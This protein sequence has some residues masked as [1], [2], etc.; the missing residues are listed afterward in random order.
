MSMS[1]AASRAAPSIILAVAL[2]AT[3]LLAG[4]ARAQVTS[5]NMEPLA[6]FNDYPVPP[7]NVAYGY[8]A[9]WSYIH[10]DGREYAVLGVGSGTAIYN[11]TDPASSYRVGFIPGPPSIWRE[12][13]SYRNW[14]YVVTEGTGAG[15]GL[16]IIR[17]TNPEAPVLAASYT[18]GFTHS[19][20]VSVDTSRALLVCN[21]TR[22]FL[23]NAAGMHVL[24]LA[25]PE[26][27][28]ELSRW[29]AGG[30]IVPFQ[31]Y[32]HDC[33]LVGN[34]LYAS[35]VYIG[36]ERVIDITNPSVPTE[37]T[38]WSYPS[39]YYCHSAWPDASGRWLYVADEQNGQTLRVFDV[40][41]IMSPVLV[42]AFTCNPASIVHNPRVKGNTLYLANYTE[43]VRVLDIS[44]PVHP[45][46]IAWADSYPGL[47]GGYGGVWE[48]CPY[49]PSGTVIASDMETG[50]YV[51]RPQ[52]DYGLLRVKV[53]DGLGAPIVDQRVNLVSQGDSLRTP[54]D[55]IVQFA[56]SPGL[57]TVRARRF[58]TFDAQAT[59]TVSVG[60]H[61]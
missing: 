13:K 17:M 10:G 53:V 40:A 25:N 18:T 27:P 33:V 56:P 4:A 50:L 12:M 43:G 20:T 59:R 32:V 45:A 3:A 34:R 55:G 7:I 48:V 15:E 47:S 22:D 9:C 61:S 38:S 54:A 23:G 1:T 35:A 6:H 36:T 19:H 49:F 30:G 2:T 24:S 52:T 31:Q 26:A 60:S 51:Y 39:A 14:I 57:H 46:E 28:V 44:D 41:N 5:R 11:V 8:S 37:V 29:P 16:Q 42:N 58:G 21:G